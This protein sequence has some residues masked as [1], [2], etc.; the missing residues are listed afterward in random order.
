MSNRSRPSC[1]GCPC[2]RSRPGC[3]CRSYRCCTPCRSRTSSRP[4]P[5]WSYPRTSVCPSRNCTSPHG[6]RWRGCRRLLPRTERS[7]RCCTLCPTCIPWSARWAGSRSPRIATIPSSTTTTPS[8]MDYCLAGNP[9]WGNTRG[10]SRCCRPCW[11]RTSSRSPCCSFPR[12]PT[13]H[14]NS[15]SRPSCTNSKAGRPR[16]LCR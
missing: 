12:R 5:P 14:S 4:T 11:S 3:T 9:G 8:C 7:C 16:P 6:R 10:S 1:T 15:W 2:R 13:L